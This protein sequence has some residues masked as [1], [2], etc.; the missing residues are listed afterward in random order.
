MFKK[1][2]KDRSAQIVY[3][4]ID[5]TVTTFAVIAA[6]A[7]AGLS[8]TYIIM[9]GLA[10][11][12]GDGFSMG[13]SA[14]LS[15]KTERDLKLSRTKDPKKR[16]LIMQEVKPFR[17]GLFTFGG[18][19]I[20]GFA[21]VVTYIVDALFDLRLAPTTLFIVSAV[22]TAVTFF[23]IGLAKA[24]VTGTNRTRGAIETLLI[25]SV[26]AILAY[27][28]GDVLGSMLGA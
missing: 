1:A 6:S 8:S 24:H 9:L 7:G 23:L 26:A 27:L 22:L 14:Y 18:F 15:K 5:G 11:Q 13:A 12:F 4:A 16:E 28:G 10:N 20:I 25:G 2:L 21:P 17:D 19:I 3:G